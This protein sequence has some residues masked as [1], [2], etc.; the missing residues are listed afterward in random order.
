MYGFCFSL[1]SFS[2]LC[3]FRKMSG[4]KTS[5]LQRFAQRLRAYRNEAQTDEQDDMSN[6]GAGVE[7]AAG[8]FEQ[9]SIQR[10]SRFHAPA[11]FTPKTEEEFVSSLKLTPNNFVSTANLGQPINCTLLAETLHGRYDPQSF[12]A[13][14]VKFSNPP[15]TICCFSSGRFLVTGA[16]SL[17]MAVHA[18]RV[19]VNRAARALDVAFDLYDFEVQNIVSSTFIGFPL[20]LARFQA[21]FTLDAQQSDVFSALRWDVVDDPAFDFDFVVIL[22]PTG[23]V[24]ITRLSAP[25]QVQEAVR[26]LERLWPYRVA[27]DCDR[28]LPVS[29]RAITSGSKRKAAAVFPP[30]DATLGLVVSTI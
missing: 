28:L 20:D 12:P 5:E 27:A 29:Q 4:I 15:V 1:M 18:A 6:C 8:Y 14:V 25:Q 26:V 13:C 19:F 7:A 16:N 10:S 23:S 30:L 22:F 11:S 17:W 24:N 21:D 2:G 3:C 9:V